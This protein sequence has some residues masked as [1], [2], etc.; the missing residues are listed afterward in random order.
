MERLPAALIKMCTVFVL[1]GVL[2]ANL[3]EVEA[4]T[5]FDCNE[6]NCTQPVNCTGGFALGICG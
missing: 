5:C 3:Q 2:L 4:L 6:V 1:V